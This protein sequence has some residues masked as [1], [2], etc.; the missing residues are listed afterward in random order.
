[1]LY[2]SGEL[3]SAMM[4]NCD[5]RLLLITTG[6][7]EVRY[8]LREHFPNV[9]VI[10]CECMDKCSV[11]DAVST[12]SCNLLVT[13]R[14]PYILP[15]SCFQKYAFG[16]YNIHPTLLPKY[17]GLNPWEA[18]FRNNEKNG[19]VTIHRLSENVDGGKILM[20]RSFPIL[21]SDTI[22]SARNMA[23]KLAAQLICIFLKQDTILNARAKSIQGCR[24]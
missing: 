21:S 16:G 19:G 12:L 18:I 1:M 10:D 5:I 13:Y 11:I 6:D 23:D 4:G 2:Q 3:K 20:Q 17:P 15:I 9:D 14:C 8:C 24:M 7:N 22:D